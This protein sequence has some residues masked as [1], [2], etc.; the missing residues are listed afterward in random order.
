MKNYTFVKNVKGGLSIVLDSYDMQLPTRS[1]S[2]A[3][4]IDQITIPENYALGLFV[5]SVSLQM[6]EEGYFSIPEFKELKNKAKE[7]GLFSDVN[8]ESVYTAKE[9]EKIIK[10]NDAK[11]LGNILNRRN[12]IEMENLIIIARENMDNLNSSTINK[13]EQACGAELRI[14]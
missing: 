4:N 7:I 1:F 11:G 2:I 5:S 3:Y 10:S 8:I 14:E 13:I 9:I 12:N 6:F